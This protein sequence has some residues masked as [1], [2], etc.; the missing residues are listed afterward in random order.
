MDSLPGGVVQFRQV[1]EVLGTASP[2]IGSSA[3][4]FTSDLSG[5]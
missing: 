5:N 1:T 4:D 2:Q 3:A